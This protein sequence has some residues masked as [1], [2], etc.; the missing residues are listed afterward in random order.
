MIIFFSTVFWWWVSFPLQPRRV[1]EERMGDLMNCS[2]G[3]DKG[4]LSPR[5][6]RY[7]G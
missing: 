6:A 2:G 5:T 3:N 1:F 4:V 7:Q